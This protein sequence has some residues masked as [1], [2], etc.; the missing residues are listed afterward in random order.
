MSSS[1][2]TLSKLNNS[3]IGFLEKPVIKYG[4][5][6]LV[7]LQI[8]FIANLSTSYLQIFDD[9]VFK[10]IFA[11]LIAYYACF[12]PVY[13]IALTTLMII[14][15]QEL[16]N[17]N[18]THS[19]ISLLPKPTMK[20]VNTNTTN[21]HTNTTH[22]NTTQNSSNTFV[23][24]SNN[25]I[26]A[27]IFDNDELVY[28]LI[29]QHSLQK[30]PSADDKLTTEYDFSNEPAYKTITDNIKKIN[31]IDYVSESKYQ[32]LVDIQDNQILNVNQNKSLQGL[33][34]DILNIQGLPN[35]FD[36]KTKYTSL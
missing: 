32:P 1:M 16:H 33:Q 3:M 4:F 20:Y 22:P 31:N 14:S 18:A 35:G 27:K 24:S 34:G 12:D 28:E 10:V 30:K 7:V 15:I 29:N 25:K 11:F 19:V 9:N 23:V 21:T 5:L 2:N 6:I 8:I 13:A 36:N 26:K 17:R